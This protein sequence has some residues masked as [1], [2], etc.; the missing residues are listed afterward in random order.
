M[1]IDLWVNALSKEAADAFLGRPGFG[2]IEGF[3][4]SDVHGGLSTTG[5]L[6]EMDRLSVDRAVLTAGL[7]RVEPE[8]IAF[9][10]EHRHRLFL[11]AAVDR[12]DRPRRQSTEIRARAADGSLDL[13]R[14]TP[15]VHQ[16]PLN[17]AL[18]YPVYA[19]CEELGIPV[20]INVGIPGPRVRSSGQDPVLLEDVLID[21]PDLVVIGAH[22]GH[23]YEALLIEY[24]LKWPNLYLSNS[25]YLAK[26]MDAGLVT[27]MG[28]R[29]GRGRVLF[30]SD[31]P[32]LPLERALEAARALPLGDEAMSEFLGG[33]AARLLE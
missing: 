9:V 24:M 32:F 5:L 3:F 15:L 2:A 25:A 33:S 14:V 22:M 21:F 1:I 18:Y 12:P 30:A 26:Y 19:T 31:H 29:R 13:V 17:H 16:Y 6:V 8:T 20:S 27:F 10:A 11:A 23:P 7:S 4:G 28:S